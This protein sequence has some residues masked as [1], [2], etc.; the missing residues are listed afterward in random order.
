MKKKL[1]LLLLVGLLF[2]NPITIVYAEET[3][4]SNEEEGIK[5]KN[6]DGEKYESIETLKINWTFAKKDNVGLH[7]YYISKNNT[8][9]IS[10]KPILIIDIDGK[11]TYCL[12]MLEWFVNS[13]L[14]EKSYKEGSGTYN[15]LLTQDVTAL[16]PKDQ[17]YT[18]D[19]TDYNALDLINLIG[20]YGAKLNKDKNDIEYYLTAQTMI[21]Q[22]IAD[23]GIY[24]SEKFY[25]FGNDY[26]VGDKKISISKGKTNE[27]LDTKAKETEIMDLVVNYSK[28]PSIFET[29][30]LKDYKLNEKNQKYIELDI[31]TIDDYTLT[32]TSECKANE[33]NT[34]LICLDSNNDNKIDL[35]LTKGEDTQNNAYVV[36]DENV[37][38]E[39]NEVTE[40]H[41][42]L[43]LTVSAPKV[44]LTHSIKFI[45]PEEVKEENPKTGDTGM[46]L[47]ITIASCALIS[48]I[49]IYIKKVRMVKDNTI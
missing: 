27:L 28:K 3:V 9:V 20:Y 37:V 29:T 39:N 38:R 44:D 42:Q 36:D 22:I 12:E 45:I 10:N 18:Y 17:K 33:E 35:G 31:N 15:K 47:I 7:R 5:N 43:V 32:D 34:K 6:P 48:A 4:N 13:T 46:L 16:I 24:P 1:I 2:G 21:W 25:G 41:N 40:I 8:E 49:I 19:K 30:E 14:Y 26:I 11:P 23:T